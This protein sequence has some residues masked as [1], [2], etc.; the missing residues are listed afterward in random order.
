VKDGKTV[1]NK[2]IYPVPLLSIYSDT[3]KNLM[4]SMKDP[5]VVLPQETR[6]IGYRYSS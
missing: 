3:M 5:D 6:I 1:I 4:D 2:E